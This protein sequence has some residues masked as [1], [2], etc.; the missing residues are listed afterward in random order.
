VFVGIYCKKNIPALRQRGCSAPPSPTLLLRHPTPGW[1]WC[2]HH[3]VQGHGAPAS[4]QATMLQGSEAQ[5][6]PMTVPR[7]TP[8][9]SAGGLCAPR[10]H[11]HHMTPGCR[12]VLWEGMA[13]PPLLLDLRCRR[14]RCDCQNVTAVSRSRTANACKVPIT[15][16]LSDPSNR[17]RASAKPSRPQER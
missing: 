14:H 8:D 2:A 9:M 3:L 12:W 17:H 1:S 7:R 6:T 13:Q 11:C 5:R 4:G 15:P 16:G 10:R